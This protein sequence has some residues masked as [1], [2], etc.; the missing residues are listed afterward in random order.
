M[1][2]PSVSRRPSA[3]QRRL[4]WALGTTVL[5]LVT[6]LTWLKLQYGGGQPYPDLS[7]PPVLPAQRLEVLAEMD[8]PAGNVA[9]SADG[10]VFV[11][12]HPF[13]QATRFGAPTLFESVHGQLRPY[14][15]VQAQKGLQGIFGMT[16]D[17]QQRLWLIEPAGLD[18]EQTRLTALDLAS[19][20]P[21][22][23]HR[24]RKGEATFAQDLRVSPDGRTVV[25]ADTGLF[26]FTPPALLVMDLPSRRVLRRLPSHASLQP[27]DWVMRT[28][29]PQG[30]HRLAFGLVTFAV[31]VD[32]I[33]ISPDGQWLTYGAMTHDT[34]FRVPLAA[35]ADPAL[36]DA[37]LSARIEPLGRKPMSDGITLD[38]QG[39]VIL[40]DV[41]NG[42]LMRREADG[43]LLTLVQDPRIVWAD[44]VVQAPDGALLFT[45]S[46]IP[47]Y[48]DQLAR[49]PSIERLA[50]GRPYRVWRLPP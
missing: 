50:A 19:G 36:D 49:P 45:D 32:G 21:V 37:A 13:A 12:V 17:R 6:G 27:Q 5:A 30:A 42:G 33:E 48:I 15:S 39:R 26:R 23:E 9:V 31:G 2:T 28:R 22:F 43:R 34:L 16:V 38:T 44:G 40:T 8:F 7:T 14:P 3:A 11:N 41:E 25:L 18:H 35:L 4:A 29:S 47:V 1:N 20:K 10:R 24:F 46:A